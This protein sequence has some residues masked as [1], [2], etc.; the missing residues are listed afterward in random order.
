[1]QPVAAR[2][3]FVGEDELR[4][5]PLQA[6]DQ[7]VEVRLPRPD[8]ADEHRRIGALSQRVGNGN[9]ILVDVETDEKRSRLCQG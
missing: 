3:G 5:L 6:P 2:A 9:R 7:F 1:M 4:G 8:R